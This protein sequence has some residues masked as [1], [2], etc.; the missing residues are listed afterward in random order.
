MHL[1]GAGTPEPDVNV[2]LESVQQRNP[3]GVPTDVPLQDVSEESIGV[4]PQDVSEESIGVK[5]QDVSEESIN[6]EGTVEVD[7]IDLMDVDSKNK[8]GYALCGN[9]GIVSSLDYVYM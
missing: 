3:L 6:I 2:T 7:S 8:E 9:S 1:V 4:K 5:Q